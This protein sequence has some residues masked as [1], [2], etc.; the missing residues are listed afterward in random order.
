MG[1]LSWMVAAIMLVALGTGAN[2]QRACPRTGNAHSKRVRALNLLKTR[3]KTPSTDDINT[4]ITLAAMVR[5]GND[6]RRWKPSMAA[7]VTGYVAK[8]IPGGV[9]TVNCDARDYA[10]RDTHIDVVVSANDAA[11]KKKHVIVEVTPEI[12]A[13]HPSWTTG[14]LHARLLHRCVRFTGWMMFDWMH[15]DASLNTVPENPNDWRAT[16]WEIHPVTAISVRQ[17]CSG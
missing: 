8:V 17:S 6:G 7:T 1:R 2:A 3:T 16:A 13:M 4:A 10:H 14:R 12:R 9:E 5:P 15:A 11:N